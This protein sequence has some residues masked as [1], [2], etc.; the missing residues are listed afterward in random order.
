MYALILTKNGFGYI[1]GDFLQAHPVTLVGTC[2]ARDVSL[3]VVIV[4]FSAF[5]FQRAF[6]MHARNQG[7]QIGRIFAFWAIISFGPFFLLRK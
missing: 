2:K 5:T 7:D 3:N 4:P 6:F 1:L